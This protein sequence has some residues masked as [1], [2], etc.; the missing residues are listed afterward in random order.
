MR[1]TGAISVMKGTVAA[2]GRDRLEMRNLQM[3]RLLHIGVNYV[4]RRGDTQIDRSLG[5]GRTPVS[6][7][8][9]LYAPTVCAVTAGHSA[10][11]TALDAVTQL[12]AGKQGEGKQGKTFGEE[13][14]A[15]G[16][17]SAS[18]LRGAVEEREET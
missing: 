4:T 1:Q 9:D 15:Q 17:A 3:Q 6:R 13:V 5:V 2:Q 8:R 11:S 7:L 10:S 16:T 18:P 14:A 12:Q